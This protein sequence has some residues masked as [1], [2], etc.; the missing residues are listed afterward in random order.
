[1]EECTWDEALD[2]IKKRFKK[3]QGK[4]MAAILGNQVDCE[5]IILLKDLFTM[6]GSDNFLCSQNNATYSSIPRVAYTFNSGIA[7]I[8]DSDF[9][10]LIGTNPRKEAAILNARIRK[11]YLQGNYEVFSIG[12]KFD[13]NYPC[14]FL[15]DNPSVLIDTVNKKNLLSKK[16]GKAKKPIIIIG[17][18]VF[19]RKDA[20]SILYYIYNLC[21]KYSVIKIAK[22]KI[23]WNGLNCLHYAASRVGALDLNFYSK[24]N[25]FNLDKVYSLSS[26]N[27]LEIIY[28]LGVDQIDVKKLSNSFV[29]YQGSHG[30]YGAEY[31][32]VVLPGSAYTEKNATYVNT[33]GRVQT[34]FKAC[35][36]PGL[37]KEDWKIIVSIGK[38]LKKKFNYYNIDD[39]RKRLIKENINFSLPQKI[40]IENK[41][42]KFGKKGRLLNEKFKLPIDNFY[43]TDPITKSSKVM[44]Q[45]SKELEGNNKKNDL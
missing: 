28:L 35:N 44:G 10:L 7:G 41:F 1:M 37:A 43:L 22:N 2:F 13:L 19:A 23:I 14:K 27:K 24:D 31:S 29:I 25:N 21:I 6:F 39:V 26:Q 12:P 45:C 17:D 36:P 5:S 11:R 32:D 9:C 4:K 38:K 34:T 20:H 8:E 16:L 33:E 3:I 40:N 42:V 15:N 18:N 30:D